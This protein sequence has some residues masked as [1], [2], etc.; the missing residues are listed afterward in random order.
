M[1]A[2]TPADFEPLKGETLTAQASEE[3]PLRLNAVVRL[4]HSR[5]EGGG[6]RLELEGPR[7]PLLEQAI[8]SLSHR[9]E[10]FEIFIVPIAQT[11]SAT[12]YE[13]VFN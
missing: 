10:T 8:Y 6:F 2:F 4:A 11:D 7:A 5:R 3:V 12:A 13:A 9:G 1:R